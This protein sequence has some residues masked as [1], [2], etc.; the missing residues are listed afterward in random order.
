MVRKPSSIISH[1]SG[2]TLIHLDGKEIKRSSSPI[3]ICFDCGAS[4]MSLQETN[5]G[6]AFTLGS[7]HQTRPRIITL[8]AILTRREPQPGSFKGTSS[9]PG[10]QRIHF[11]GSTENVRLSSL[12]SFT[13]DILA[14]CCISWLWQEHSLVRRP[15]SHSVDS[16]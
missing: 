9:K 10:S 8:L 1:D 5:C 2:L 16:Y 6:T 7:P 4:L 13:P 14:T 12:A 11:F 3:A 15:S